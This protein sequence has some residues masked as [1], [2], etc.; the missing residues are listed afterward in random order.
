MPEATAERFGRC[1]FHQ[2]VKD[3]HEDQ[4]NRLRPRI[5]RSA[6]GLAAAPAFS[7]ST[8]SVTFDGWANDTAGRNNGLITR[9]VYLDEMGRRW[10]AMPNRQGTREAYLNSL[11]TR[12]DDVDRDNRGMTPAQVSK[13]T[14]KV[15]SSTEQMPKSG[16]G[17]QPGNMGPGNSKAQ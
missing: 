4:S 1:V 12:W 10:E 5:Q 3:V 7:Q 17:V 13:L 6:G 14:G 2:H 15:D 11:R 9:D 8:N 16:S